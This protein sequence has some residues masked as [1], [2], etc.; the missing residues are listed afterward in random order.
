MAWDHRRGVG[1]VE[2]ELFSFRGRKTFPAGIRF[3]LLLVKPCLTAAIGLS[4]KCG[5][6]GTI[7]TVQR[8]SAR[9]LLSVLRGRL[10]QCQ[11]RSM[12]SGLYSAAT[13]MDAAVQRHE[14]A[15]EN[16]ANIQMPG[17]RRR[18]MSQSTFDT[19]MPPLDP[20]TSG[21]FSTR[22]L[23]TATS[24]VRFDFS[25]GGLEDTKRPLDV[26]I[27]GDGFFT[28]QGSEGPLYTR[29]GSFH[30]APDGTLTTIDNLPVLSGGRPIV[31]PDGATS[32]NIEIARDGRMYSND[33]EF[34][35]L[36]VVQFSDPGV[37]TA[38]GATLFAS[39][40]ISMAERVRQ[41]RA[42]MG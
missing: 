38:A 2:P 26:A 6:I 36:D 11:G 27:T 28:V 18:V 37:L 40:A 30:V 22:L 14:M 33:Q 5:A 34:A 25:Q 16:L 39:R 19:V 10:G 21:A 42:I 32:E 20:G 17:Y 4:V 41:M 1:G 15:A 31:L 9:E 35:Q 23:G 8:R 7:R 3:S 29:N 24:P 13:S 12:I